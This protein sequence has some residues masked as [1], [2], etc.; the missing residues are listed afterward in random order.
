[1]KIKVY[2][3]IAEARQALAADMGY[4]PF[5]C[6][7]GRCTAAK[8]AEAGY[9]VDPKEWQWQQEQAAWQLQYKKEWEATRQLEL[10]VQREMWADLEKEWEAAR[11]LELDPEPG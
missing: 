2:R 8:L 1:M 3:T 4:D 5:L 11:Q 10:E 7:R 9:H 6:G